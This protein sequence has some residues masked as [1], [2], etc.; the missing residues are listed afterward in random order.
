MLTLL[1]FIVGLVLGAV[2]VGLL[3]LQRRVSELE[4]GPRLPYK[5]RSGLDDLSAIDTDTLFMI[6]DALL[7]VEARMGDKRK[8][9]A[10]IRQGRY[11]AEQP[12]AQRRG[13]GASKG[14]A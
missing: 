6:R 13:N 5:M 4:K 1:S 10:E 2:A 3:E 14:K 8:L 12:A 11:D 7:V 9:M